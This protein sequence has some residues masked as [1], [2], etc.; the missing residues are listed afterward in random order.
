MGGSHCSAPSAL[1]SFRSKQAKPVNRSVN[2]YILTKHA[3]QLN[4]CRR[5]QNH[6]SYHRQQP[7]PIVIC[8]ERRPNL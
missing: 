8:A 1:I 4:V 2:S 3:A 5:C 6:S 7:Q